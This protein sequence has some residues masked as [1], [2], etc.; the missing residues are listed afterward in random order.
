MSIAIEEAIEPFLYLVS[1]AF[2]FAVLA[3]F[4]TTE[5]A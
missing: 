4:I 1:L 5:E 2:C 3:Y